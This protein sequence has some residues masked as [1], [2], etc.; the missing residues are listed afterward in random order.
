MN[1][2]HRI[3]FV[4][5]IL[6][7][8]LFN[9]ISVYSQTG[10]D[11][12]YR[13]QSHFS[14]AK[15]W[16]NDPCGTIY[17]DS[18]YHLMYQYNPL[19]DQWGNMSW[20]HAVSPDLVHWE[21]LPV[22]LTVDPIGAI[23][24]GSAV[25]DKNNTA[26][27]G[28]NAMVAIFTHAGAQQHQSIAYSVDNGATWL[29]YEGNP[30]LPNQGVADFRDPQVFWYE[31]QSKW[32]MTLA[33]KDRIQ[34]FSSPNLTEW[35]FESEFG[36][37]IGSHAGVWECPDLFPLKVEGTNDSKWV[38]I[39]SINPG[40]PA[41]GS[42]TQYFVGEF[43]GHAFHPDAD[44]LKAFEVRIPEG[45]LFADFETSF[46]N[47]TIS[48]EAFSDG[49]VSGSLPNQ[50]PVT[51]YTGSRLINSY[52]NGD[53]TKGKLTSP[54]FEIT[55]DHI[56]FLIGGGNR[57]NEAE[58]RL[59]VDGSIVRRTTGRN[60]ERLLWANWNVSDMK[61]KIAR[62]EIADEATGGWGHINVDHII[63]SDT[64]AANNSLE[65]FWVDFGPDFYA[66]RSWEN[67]P[68]TTNAERVWIAWMS[69][70][71][72]AGA[73]PT[74]PWRGAMSLPRAMTLKNTSEGLRLFQQPV[75]QFASILKE[76]RTLSTGTV[77]EVNDYLSTN[78]VKS[79][80][81]K[82][83]YRLLTS[84]DAGVKVRSNSTAATRIGY[85]PV[86]HRVYVDRSVSGVL[87]FGSGFDNFFEAPI[88]ADL[89]SLQF[90]IYVDHSS[91][92]VFVNN[93][94][95]V[96]T[97]LIFPSETM[98]QIEFY[99]GNASDTRIFNLSFNEI[100]S[101]WNDVILGATTSLERGAIRLYPN[102]T[103]GKV[104]IDTMQQVTHCSL[105]SLS[106]KQIKVQ[107]GHISSTEIEINPDK[108]LRPG[109]YFLKIFNAQDL[110][111]TKK[112][113]IK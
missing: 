28:E 49:P 59:I 48:G 13:P 102:P 94:G 81:F 93:G 29:K 66:G 65:A 37:T 2:V 79:K 56:N 46:D 16:I 36:T 7:F 31:P 78:N 24:S 5:L 86:E 15:N 10:Y 14:P 41:G 62:I 52:R 4:E 42:G 89:D 67:L 50:Q 40:G 38:M 106:G 75:Q 70:W 3:F 76:A 73:I 71:A 84:A 68:P 87:P 63:F 20:G 1:V 110:I 92:E 9:V 61:G 32:I 43:D 26:G 21:E 74:S 105:F 34:I 60:E 35:S 108:D 12:L 18:M 97:S 69:N 53:D 96:L 107:L 33:V 104:I 95:V 44:F 54:S 99:T 77:A 51:G 111:E 100:E 82:I 90:D 17:Y 58:V 109:I 112:V 27:F 8:S 113:V 83:S 23:F 22:A 30:V 64:P 91:V 103:T 85:N 98:D 45:V 47:W 55:L 39:V 57:P 88:S 80:H 101:I 72:Y 19:G 6:L 25:I 11:A